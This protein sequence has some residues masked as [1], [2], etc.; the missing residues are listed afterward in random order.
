MLS[1][2][3]WLINPK[4]AFES[5]SAMF[6][7]WHTETYCEKNNEILDI[8]CFIQHCA[9]SPR[10]PDF[11]WHT[12]QCFPWWK[13]RIKHYTLTLHG[14]YRKS[15]YCSCAGFL[16]VAEKSIEKKQGCLAGF[17]S[18][19]PLS[20]LQTPSETQNDIETNHNRVFF[21]PT[22]TVHMPFMVWQWLEHIQSLTGLLPFRLWC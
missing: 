4:V 2:T 16:V 13:K 19:V 6:K 21:S 17:R 10:G 22:R 15:I 14:N 3:P 5:C 20:H 11:N 18:E 12:V 1:E 7:Q 9:R 8:C